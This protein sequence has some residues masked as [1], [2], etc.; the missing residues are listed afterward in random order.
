MWGL[1]AKEEQ[2][3][4]RELRQFH[5]AD[6]IPRHLMSKPDS[7][8]SWW[9]LGGSRRQRNEGVSG[10][11]SSRHRSSG[12]AG[13][14]DDDGTSLLFTDDLL[15]DEVGS[16]SES[17]GSYV[18]EEFNFQYEHLASGRPRIFNDIITL[19]NGNHMTKVVISHGIAQSCKLLLFEVRMDSTL[20][21][22]KHIPKLLAMTGN[23]H[24]SP[25]KITTLT[26]QLYRLRMDLTLVS[27]YLDQPDLVW[28]SPGWQPL[29]RA[30]QGYLEIE[31]RSKTLN[32]RAS[33]LSDLLDM[34]SSHVTSTQADW[35]T[36]V[37]IILITVD[38]I[39]LA[40]E[41]VMKAI[42]LNG[43]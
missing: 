39:V 19:K 4:L 37:V 27:N 14:F 32:L 7:T 26:G 11:N 23:V 31:N 5:D 22:T 3:L 34:L 8:S 13:G 16:L 20:D 25:S 1:T 36:W 43:E 6:G 29:Y 18:T 42:K 17:D 9:P 21:K 40:M 10:S 33:V 12:R 38:V 28:T 30:V 35:M 41:I 2:W 24:L 15:E